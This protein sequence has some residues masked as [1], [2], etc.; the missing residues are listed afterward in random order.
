MTTNPA[1]PRLDD[2]SQ[3]HCPIGSSPMDLDETDRDRTANDAFSRLD[4]AD[5]WSELTRQV[6]AEIGAI[7]IELVAT[8]RLQR[9]VY[10][11]QLGEI[12]Q[13]AADAADHALRHL[14]GCAESDVLT[15]GAVEA[16]GSVTP[17]LPSLLGGICRDC[18]CTRLFDPMDG[19]ALYDMVRSWSGNRLWPYYEG[20]PRDARDRWECNAVQRAGR[21]AAKK[22]E[23]CDAV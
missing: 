9:R 19:R 20:L 13:R 10:E 17:R 16:E 8:W 6:Q 21:I 12:L 5:I 15:D 4:G 18:G 22:A 1:C 2:D 11:D 23:A 14:L 3:E 7:A